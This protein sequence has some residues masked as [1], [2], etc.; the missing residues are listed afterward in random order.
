[1]LV[2]AR[3][4][5]Q[6]REQPGR[7]HGAGAG[8]HRGGGPARAVQPRL[9]RRPARRCSASTPASSRRATACRA[10]PT[11]EVDAGARADRDAAGARARRAVGRAG[12]VRRAEPGGGA[13]PHARVVVRRRATA[14]STRRAT[15][16]P[17]PRRSSRAGVEVRERTAFTGLRVDGGRVVGVRTPARATS[18]PTP[19]V[20]TGGPEPGR[21]RRGGGRADP[22]RRHAAPGRR[23]RAAPGP[24]PGAAADGLRRDVGHL[25]AA[26]GGRPAVGHEQP[27][28]AAG[29]RPASST[30]TTSQLMRARV[31]DAAARRPAKLGVRRSLGRHHRLHARPP[32]DPRP[33]ARATTGRSPA[34]SSPPPAATG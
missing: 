13:G 14:T 24:R 25:L 26:R 3:H 32:A 7:R 15:C 16:S 27:R 21:G 31:A 11:A 5:R 6:G 34:R 10:S 4:P 23:H 29:P 30:T 9:L 2:E 28:R 18:P 22:G 17:T 33:V 12:R 20:L 8:R 19:V 1:M